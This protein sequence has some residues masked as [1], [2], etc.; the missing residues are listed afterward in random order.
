VGVDGRDYFRTDEEAFTLN[1]LHYFSAAGTVIL[2]CSCDADD[3]DLHSLKV[4]AI[5]V[6]SYWNVPE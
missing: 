5:R 1:V 4:T 6:N 2:R 3:A